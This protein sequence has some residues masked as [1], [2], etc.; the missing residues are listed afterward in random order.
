MPLFDDLLESLKNEPAIPGVVE[1]ITALPMEI[2]LTDAQVGSLIDRLCFWGH[3]EA[4]IAEKQMQVLPIIMPAIPHF[5][6]AKKKYEKLLSFALDKAL[7]NK[8][9]ELETTCISLIPPVFSP[10]GNLAFLLFIRAFLKEDKDETEKYLYETVSQ[11]LNNNYFSNDEALVYFLQQEELIRGKVEE[12]KNGINRMRPIVI[13][14]KTLEVLKKK[15]YKDAITIFSTAEITNYNAKNST[16]TEIS[17][18]LPK[19]YL[20]KITDEITAQFKEALDKAVQ[21][22]TFGHEFN[23]GY[24]EKTN[25]VSQER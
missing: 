8:N 5:K 7:L 13:K 23:I 24:V 14:D 20:G 9:V 1:K 16:E 18:G 25:T 17:I 21:I 2:E 19:E 12:V 3:T 10:G 6:M 4:E 22:K 15:K 11:N